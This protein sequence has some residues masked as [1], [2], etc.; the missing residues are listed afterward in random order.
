MKRGA[1]ATSAALALILVAGVASAVAQAAFKVAVPAQGG[2]QEPGRG[3]LHGV[4][5]GRG[6]ARPPS[7]GDGQGDARRGPRA[8]RQAPSR[9]SPD[10]RPRLRRGRGLRPVVHGVHHGLRPVRGLALRARTATASM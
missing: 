10:P 6:R 7:G 5:D 4:Q 2:R 3:G 8:D 9:P 1:A